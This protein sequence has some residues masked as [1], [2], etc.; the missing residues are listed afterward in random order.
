MTDFDPKGAE[1]QYEEYSK[2]L[3]QSEFLTSEKSFSIISIYFFVSCFL[4]IHTHAR[5]HTHPPLQ[6]IEIFILEH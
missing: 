4:H 1:K 6:G 5:T 2:I 3:E